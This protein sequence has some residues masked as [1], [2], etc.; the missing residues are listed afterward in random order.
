MAE[1]YTDLTLI[2][3]LFAFEVAQELQTLVGDFI[4]YKDKESLV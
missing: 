3:L 2:L 1:I 4:G